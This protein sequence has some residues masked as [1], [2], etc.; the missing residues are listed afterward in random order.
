VDLAAC[1]DESEGGL[2]GRVRGDV[3]WG[4]FGQGE[5]GAEESGGVVE[6][7]CVDLDA[8]FGGEGEE[9]GRFG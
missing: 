4:E 8:E 3:D 5:L 6:V 7:E 1:A 2:D 9:G